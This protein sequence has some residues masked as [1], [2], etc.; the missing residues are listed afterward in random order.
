MTGTS[1]DDIVAFAKAS[2]VPRLITFSEDYI[3]P[4]FGDHNP[5]VILFT[6]EADQSY[7][8]AFADAAKQLQGEILF[9]T[10]GISEGIQARLGEF[11]GLSKEDLPSM[12]II[13]PSEQML[14]YNWEG[15]V[16]KMVTDDVRKFVTDFKAGTLSP[17]L[18]SDPIPDPQ[19]VNGLTTV[20]G[21]SFEA[22]VKDPSKDVL[23]KYYAPW[24]GHCK[25]LAP[26]WDE[27][28]KDLESIEDLVIA[29]FDATTN[30]VAGLDI[31]GYPTLKFYPKN[32][33]DGM[34]YSG[35]RQLPDFLKFLSQHSTAYQAARPADGSAATEEL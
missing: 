26:V 14:K 24:C 16:S 23:V 32:N 5:A 8:S 12:R 11:I 29:K 7:Q 19:T 31:R 28:A 22:V 15:D 1:E 2:S 25:A 34:D 21:K 20:V 30:E 35:D 17:H 10:S 6:E 13:S 3:E 27:M 33:K 18:K 9:V 4:I